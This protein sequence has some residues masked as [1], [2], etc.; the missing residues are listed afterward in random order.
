MPIMLGVTLA[1]PLAENHAR[2]TVWKTREGHLRRPPTR[3][4]ACPGRGSRPGPL[5]DKDEGDPHIM[6][7]EHP[8]REMA[9]LTADPAAL[10]F[11]HGTLIRDALRIA[12]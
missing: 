5:R 2:S 3:R 12:L 10:A 7:A 4:A 11:D 6:T 1:F 8:E 9:S